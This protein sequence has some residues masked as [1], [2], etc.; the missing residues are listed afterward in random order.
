ML[1][2]HKFYPSGAAAS[3]RL[4]REQTAPE[5]EAL[6]LELGSQSSGLGVEYSPRREK[7]G[8]LMT[9]EEF[10]VGPPNGQSEIKGISFKQT[11]EQW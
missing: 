9:K 2:F 11:E 4:G 6:G 10:P 3:Y 7:G 5:P 8:T 1:A